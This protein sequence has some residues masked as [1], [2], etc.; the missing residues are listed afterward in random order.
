MFLDSF[1]SRKLF[2]YAAFLTICCLV[3]TP[4]V[5]QLDFDFGE[6]GAGPSTTTVDI[7]VEADYTPATATQSAMVFVTIQIP[8][9]MHIYAVDQEEGGP[10]ATSLIVNSTQAR[11]SGPWQPIQAP[12]SHSY[13]N[14][15]PG[16]EV[17]EHTG[18]V[19]WYAPIEFSPGTDINSATL[20]VTATV[21]ACDESSCIQI[22]KTVAAKLGAGIAIPQKP[23][24]P[25][26]TPTNADDTPL[27]KVIGFAILGGLILN[28]MPCVLP[29]IG[30]KVLSFA[31]QGGQSRGQIFMLNM[32]YV[33]GMILVFI[34]L[35]TLAS[36]VQ[37]GLGNESLGWGE[38]NTHTWFKVGMASL[39]FAMALSFLGTWEIPIPGFASSGKATELSSREGPLGAFMMG[40]FTTILATPCSGPFLGPVFGYLISQ[41][42]HITY[43]VF[44]SVGLGMA[45]PYILIGIF[46]SLVSWLPKP[47]A[48]MDTFKQLL[49]FV[50]LGT[51][52]WLMSAISK[53][54]FI[55]TLSL[56][57][58]I[59]F[60]CWWIGS[61][62][63]TAPSSAKM[64]AWLGGSAVAAILGYA[65][66]SFLTP[67][68]SVLP[69]QPWSNAA[70]AEA[71]TQ[72]KTVLV[73]FSAQWCLTC[74]TN[75]KVA[76]NREEVKELVEEN[77]VVTLLADWTDKNPEIKQ[78]L[79][80][81]NSQSI[82]LL[83]IYP[84]DPMKAPI[85]LPDLLSKQ[86]VLDA[87]EA[88][89]PSLNNE[90]Q[91]EV[92]TAPPATGMS[93]R[94]QGSSLVQ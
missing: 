33:A 77:E 62:P 28:L 31:K 7:T 44:A 20:E 3:T 10:L 41:P 88:A 93:N 63:I 5:A 54:Y 58:A 80:E 89:G 18:K 4:A 32:A 65:A 49:G 53:D 71:R 13:P 15:W 16:V 76:I 83:V 90:N 38:L 43:T 79:L 26:P 25:S 39:V 67:G 94:Y 78:A 47:G 52:V 45:L 82:P 91:S 2:V 6:F 75:L 8:D 24:A 55:A 64:R 30:L 56:L 46:P 19:T 36:L 92:A 84:A 72:G 48:W 70:L 23:Q 11:L 57:F 50:L 17:K 66:F 69:W 87:L 12:V 42:V 34:I 51:V 86:Q 60:A 37:L 35:A 61:T 29:V 68:D 81:H 9:E 74:K 21:Q 73:D 40:I 22:D 14:I 59:W 85:V 1:S 27:L